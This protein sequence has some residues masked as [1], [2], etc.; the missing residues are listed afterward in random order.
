MNF[1][2]NINSSDDIKK[3][4]IKEL[5]GLAEDI[6]KFLIENV[7]YTGGHLASNLGIVELTLAIHKV[8][9]FPTDKI[10]FDVG[11][12]S[13]VHKIITGR[14]ERF[15]TLRKF[16]GISGFPKTNESEYDFF[17]TGHSSNSLSIALG[18]KR[19]SELNGIKNNVIALLGDGSFGGGMIYEA[20]N[21]AG[22]NKDNVI[23]IL[24][25][26]Q[27]SISKNESSISK[28]LGKLRIKHSYIDAKA[29]WVNKLSKFKM[30]KKAIS[31]TK[32]IVKRAMYRSSLFEDLGIKYYG[33]FD[34]HNIEELVN[35]L[36]VTKKING[37]V[38][39]HV[40]TKKGKGYSYAELNPEKF[41]GISP[42]NIQTGEKLNTKD[43]YSKIF[44]LELLNI[45]QKNDKVI[46][47]T[48]AMPSGTGLV[49]F[50]Q[51]FPERYFDVG[52]CEEHAVSLCA[53]MAAC[54]YIPVFA[55]YSSFLQ[56]GYDQII[57]DVAL[58]NH[59]VIFAID[60]AGI[61]GEDGETHQGIFD[62]S[63]LNSIPNMTVLSPASFDELKLMLN[64]AVD[65]INGP[66]AI[67]YPRGGESSVLPVTPAI[68]KCKASM[69]HR[70]ED[71]TIV[72]EGRSVSTALK[73]SAMLAGIGKTADVINIR[74]IKPL[75][76]CTI[77][78]SVQKTKKLIVIEEN[79]K[80]GGLGDTILS[81]L[82][83]IQ[84]K[85]LG[86][87]IDDRFVEHGSYQELAKLLKLDE[88]SIFNDIKEVFGF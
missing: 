54:G 16:K 74:F 42:F 81:M 30:I 36:E 68:D 71:L 6:R 34:G 79:V 10:I 86:K 26:N 41:H 60:R 12:Q 5:N 65:K 33:P 20:I 8:F 70:G 80:C 72:A 62:I 35:I 52:I 43:D 64:F 27:M 50:A 9:N 59:H 63:Y 4:N 82:N 44:G 24:N 14:K 57:T 32:S 28:Y 84:F 66:V 7:S 47:I 25:D 73:L 61:V 55:V 23:I 38:L 22:H 75:D 49:P 2:N 83:G 3:M 37:P 53:G 40:S 18:M 1:L 85:Y 21:D 78:E 45:A 17:D 11:H 46:G 19:A 76:I 58:M 56:R 51:E 39:I 88:E 13:Y 15:N 67:R 29:K 77:S 31:S 48:A 69:L 87:S